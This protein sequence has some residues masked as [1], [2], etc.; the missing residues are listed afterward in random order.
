MI[1]VVAGSIGA[2]TAAAE[3]TTATLVDMVYRAG[4]VVL[5]TLAA[6]RARRWT[7]AVGAGLVTVGASGWWGV[8][9][10]GALGT[11]LALSWDRR[12]RRVIAAAAGAAIGVTALHLGWPTTTFGTAVLAAVAT[13]PIWCSAYRTS[14]RL[15]RR[16]IRITAAVAAVVTVFGLVAVVAFGWT[17]RSNV[18]SAIDQALDAADRIGASSTTA[19][20]AGFVEAHDRLVQ[21]V[22]ASDAP[23]MIPA[24]LLPVVGSNL[25]AIRDSAAAGADLAAAAS[26]LSS[27]VDY[28]RLH[29]PGG[30]ID[31]DVL[32]SFRDPLNETER[33]LAASEAAL[34]ENDSPFLFAPVA[35]R[36]SSLARRVARAQRDATTARMGADV[37]P[38]LLGADGPRRYLLLLGNPSEARDI[39]G[40]LGNWAEIS[41]TDGRLHVVRVGEPYDLFG[42]V[43]AHRPF[44]PDAATFPRSLTEMN[45]TAYPQNWGSSPD[46]PTVA[47]LAAELFPQVP[48][49]GPLDGVLYA[50][51][52]AFAAALA[53]TGP[54]RIPGTGRSLDSTNA[55]AFLERGQFAEFNDSTGDRAVTELVR[56]ALSRLLDGRL[57]SPDAVA[58]NFGPVTADGHLRFVS[59]HRDEMPF[60]RRLG[61][62]GAVAPVHGADLLA[63]I[64]RNVNPSKIDSY[65][66]RSVTDR[67]TFDPRTGDV[68]A[69]VEITLV[70]TAPPNGLAKAVGNPPPG[71]PA[72][73]NR[74][75]VAV[76]TP[77][78][79]TAAT[80]DGVPVAIGTQSDVHGLVRH[81]ALVDLAPGQTRVLVVDL[82]GRVS[83]PDY[84]LRWFSQ[85]LVNPERAT[86]V[87]RSTGAPF[88]GGITAG[89]VKLTRGDED[90]TI[91][92]E[93]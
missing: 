5:T 40:H 36:M 8:A 3:P 75:E 19:S 79:A 77:F 29:Q 21:V 83:G 17:Q 62:E 91:R 66:E 15:V 50:D 45:P 31:L 80:I 35:D 43:S 23:W 85:P 24:R 41:A 26:R 89:S 1:C 18:E 16:R 76:L 44:L 82:S 37:A 61:L 67:V 70:N 47:R 68:A 7:L 63:V 81:S 60:L 74:T 71:S 56:D 52:K 69:R 30:G 42:P 20:T 28:D 59:M 88:T 92:T 33:R 55:A 54:V 32:R 12:R 10:L 51:T 84:R 2:I 86:L 65:L 25:A 13:V 49:G 4:F 39:G 57:P 6:S 48:G 78:H 64:N 14:G 53:I 58:R 90:L 73:T 72:G 38:G 9:G 87:I 46:L 93:R 22:A 34:R 11:T 27:S